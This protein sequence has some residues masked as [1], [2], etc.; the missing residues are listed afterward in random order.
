[1]EKMT[2]LLTL[3]ALLMIA[4]P[5]TAQNAQTSG[6]VI[7]NAQ[8]GQAQVPQPPDGDVNWKGVGIGAGTVAGNVLYVPAKL[9]YGILGG[10][11]G[12]A[13]YLLTGGNTQTAN[14]IWRSSLGGD[15]VLTP[16]MVSG[17]KPIHFSGPTLTVP[18]NA[19]A[20]PASPNAASSVPA[21]TMPAKTASIEAGSSRVNSAPIASDTA[22]SGSSIAQPADR[23]TGPVSPSSAISGNTTAKGSGGV[24]VAP[25]PGTSIE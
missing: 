21:A 19:T 7:G 9:V 14:T 16:D 6:L 10:I 25:L 1:M 23:G 22:M 13:S 11:T 4:P 5:A 2:C 17:Q 8:N 20:A 24:P 12:G 15:Y 3:A 18:A